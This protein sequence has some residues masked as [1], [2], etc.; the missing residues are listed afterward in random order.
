MLD[1]LTALGAKFCNPAQF[2][3][4]MTLVEDGWSEPTAR[5]F[6]AQAGWEDRMCATWLSMSQEDRMAAV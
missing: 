1:A 4:M 6:L 3:F 5:H 2:L